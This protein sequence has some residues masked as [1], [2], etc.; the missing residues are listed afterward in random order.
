L[1]GQDP[2]APDR[3][4]P[5]KPSPTNLPLAGI[6]GG[7]PVE[8]A[9]DLSGR[10]PGTRFVVRLALYL[11]GAAGAA[12]CVALLV[13]AGLAEVVALVV[14]AGAAVFAVAAFHL[15]PLLADTLA[16]RRLLPAGDR[17]RLHRLLGMRWIGESVNGLLPVAQVGGDIVRARLVGLAGAPAATA[18]ASVVVGITAGVLTQVLFAMLGLGLLLAMPA[19]GVAA[20]TLLIGL[21]TGAL[22]VAGFCAVQ[23]AGMVRI[24]KAVS[25]RFIHS[26]AWQARLA[27]GRSLDAAIH[28]LYRDRRGFAACCAWTMISWVAGAGEVWLA[29]SVLGHPV[30]FVEAL[31]LESAGQAA[32]GGFFFVPAGLGVQEGGLLVVGQWLGVPPEISLAMSV[33]KR[34][35]ELIFGVPGLVA[36]Q[37]VEARHLFGAAGSRR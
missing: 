32:R 19:P 8:P 33:L 27:R 15:V 5:M 34:I 3:L 2:P 12:L 30:G 22:C 37:V 31:I 29:L 14:S 1:T 35:R 16:W 25:S 36:W 9:D 11:V 7:L 20:G 13:R 4:R 24:L 6:A 21:A 10:A 23:R 28:A 18:A 26:G 17:P